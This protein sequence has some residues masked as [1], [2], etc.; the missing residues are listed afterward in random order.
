M[1]ELIEENKK[2]GDLLKFELSH[3]Y[4]RKK[5]PVANTQS[6]VFGQVVAMYESGGNYVVCGHGTAHATTNTAVICGVALEDGDATSAPASVLVLMR[7]GIVAGRELVFA[8]TA[9]TAQKA[10][11]CADLEKLGIVVA[12]SA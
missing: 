4:S 2:L 9:T 11:A 8:P 1:S 6:V 3:N 10:K 5:L 7:V 12:E